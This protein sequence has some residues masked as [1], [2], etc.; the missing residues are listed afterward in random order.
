M[1][2]DYI[3]FRFN[4]VLSEEQEAWFIAYFKDL[5]YSMRTYMEKYLANSTDKSNIFFQ[6]QDKLN[7]IGGGNNVDMSFIIRGKIEILLRHYDRHI[8]LDKEDPQTYTFYVETE[9]FE[10]QK[11]GVKYIDEQVF[12]LYKHKNKHIILDVQRFVLPKMQ[13]KTSDMAVN[14]GDKIL[15]SE[16]IERV[17]G[18]ELRH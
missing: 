10:F 16:D 1:K 6:L 3:T 17:L 7:M 4:N 9:A 11:T 12:S 8:M 14:N 15:L 18:V 13:L 5:K 2:Y